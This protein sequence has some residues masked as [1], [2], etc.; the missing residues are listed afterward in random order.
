MPLLGIVTPE[1]LIPVGAVRFKVPPH[2]PADELPDFTLRPPGS[3]A[4]TPA[5]VTATVFPDG[6]VRVKTSD[7]VAPAVVEDGLYTA[8]RVGG[9]T[10][11]MDVSIWPVDDPMLEVTGDEK[12][13]SEPAIIALALMLNVQEVPAAMVPLANVAAL[14]TMVTVPVPQAV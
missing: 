12:I 1:I 3:V 14:P 5:C 11:G 10:T 2:A 9:D 4:T 13:W 8:D 6:L 7:D